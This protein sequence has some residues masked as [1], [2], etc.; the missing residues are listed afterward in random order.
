LKKWASYTKIKN[1][2]SNNSTIAVAI[3]SSLL[4]AHHH[5]KGHSVPSSN[6]SMQ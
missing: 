4:T 6:S 2:T 5:I 1:N 3:V